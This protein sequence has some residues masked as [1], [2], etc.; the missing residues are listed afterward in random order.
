MFGVTVHYRGKT[1]H[2]RSYPTFAQALF[3]AHRWQSHG[4]LTSILRRG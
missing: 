4:A 1:H 3:C 2:T